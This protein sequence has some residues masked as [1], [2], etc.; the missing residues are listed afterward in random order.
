MIAA[1]AAEA[2]FLGCLLQTRAATGT[3]G[4]LAQVED[5]DFADPRHVAVLTAMRTL[6]E[7][8]SPVDPITV[9]GQLRRSG[10][11]ALMTADKRAAV[12]LADLLAAPPSVGSV[13]HYL[14]IV[15][16]HTVRRS[17]ETAAVRLQQVAES[18]S[19]DDARDVTR[20]DYQEL[21]RQ[22]G[23]LA[24]RECAEGGESQ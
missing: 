9:E 6:V 16:E 1:P 18:S 14:M 23:R 20:T 17:I 4:Y 11:E 13:G 3:R 19:L 10:V 24:A 8:G 2:A 15:L 5:G 12:F 22:F 7:A 21:E